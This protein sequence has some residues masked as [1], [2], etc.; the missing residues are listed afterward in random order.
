MEKDNIQNITIRKIP[1][2]RN[3]LGELE[4][5]RCLA[6]VARHI[7]EFPEI[8]SGNE[9]DPLKAAIELLLKKQIP[10]DIQRKIGNNQVEK[11]DI[12]NMFTDLSFIE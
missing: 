8:Y 2:S 4:R 5:T 6:I 10:L 7:E 9:S 1:L 3:I 11:F 12:N